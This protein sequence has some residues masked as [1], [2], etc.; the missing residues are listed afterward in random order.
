M[1]KNNFIIRH[2]SKNIVAGII[3]ASVLS[4]SVGCTNNKK[5]ENQGEQD[6]TAVGSDSSQASASINALTEQE[7]SEGWK[8]LFD[9]TSVDGFRG[10]NQ[11]SFP[12][13]GWQVKDGVLMVESTGTEESGFG[14]DIITKDQ[15]KDFE[16]KVDF[17]LSPKGNSGILY[18]VQEVKGQ[19]AWHNAPEYQLLDNEAYRGGDIPLEKHSTGDNYDLVGSTVNAMKP[20]GEWNEAMI[21]IK[22]KK[23][24]HWLNGQKVVEYTL[25]SPEWKELVKKSK[26]KDYPKYGMAEKGHIGIQD[27]GHQL[28][29]RNIKIREI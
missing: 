7:Q 1:I 19:P 17:K 6:T 23:V 18:L 16:F 10:Y 2:L 25:G 20:V 21:R 8:L 12:S 27:H 15:Y 4:I 22:D 5:E 3:A 13:K 11:D 14:G 29:Y 24:E 9:G 26:F 28:W